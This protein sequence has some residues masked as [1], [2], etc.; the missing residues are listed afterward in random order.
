MGELFGEAE[1]F[2]LAETAGSVCF[3]DSGEFFEEDVESVTLGLFWAE[4]PTPV[5]TR[6]I[7]RA[8]VKADIFFFGSLTKSRQK[9]SGLDFSTEELVDLFLPN[10]DRAIT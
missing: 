1:A 5:I 10:L 6:T 7:R 4:N 8:K 3:L 9:D 2:G